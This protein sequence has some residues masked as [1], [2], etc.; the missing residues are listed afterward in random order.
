MLLTLATDNIKEMMEGKRRKM[1]ELLKINLIDN[2]NE[3]GKLEIEIEPPEEEQKSYRM[4]M[5]RIYNKQALENEIIIL[6][7]TS[8]KQKED[9]H[10]N[11]LKN[12]D[13]CDRN[14]DIFSMINSQLIHLNKLFTNIRML[15]ESSLAI[16][17]RYKIFLTT[18]D[19]QEKFMRWMD[20]LEKLF[21]QTSEYDLD[22]TSIAKEDLHEDSDQKSG[23]ESSISME[24]L[25][26]EVDKQK[27]LHKPSIFDHKFSKNVIRSG[28]D[29]DRIKSPTIDIP[30]S[31]SPFL[32]N[33]PRM[34]A[35][36]LK[37]E[38][39]L[40]EEIFQLML[41][42]GKIPKLYEE[43]TRTLQQLEIIKRF[44]RR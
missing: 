5:K 36:D 10:K 33:K 11:L 43:E 44:H 35:K 13:I 23:V 12:R 18:Q 26:E 42:K 21:L 9:L 8:S 1:Q 30:A 6:R 31:P 22:L 20:K 32:S 27:D 40:V 17:R 41:K 16:D 19:R 3:F 14:R 29:I 28:V 39:E 38:E 2:A 24:S 15:P 34:L 7:E 37:T 25:S 4:E